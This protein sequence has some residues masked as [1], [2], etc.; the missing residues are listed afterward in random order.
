[1][2]KEKQY[3]IAA[4]RGRDK[5]NPSLLTPST[6]NFEQRLEIGS[7]EASN[8]LTTV[9]KDNLVV[10]Q[11]LLGWSRDDNGGIKNFHPVEVSNCIT[12]AKR[13]NTQNYVAETTRCIQVA[14]LHQEGRHDICNRVYSAE[15]TSPTLNTCGGGGLEPKILCNTA[16]FGKQYI[17]E[18]CPTI[19]SSSWEH[20][21]VLIE[22]TAEKELSPRQANKHYFRTANGTIE[23][24]GGGSK[25]EMR[26]TEEVYTPHTAEVSPTVI[27]QRQNQIYFTDMEQFIINGDKDG[28]ASTI[29]TAHHYTGNIT[30]PKGGHKEMGVLEINNQSSTEMEQTIIQKVGDRNN[31]SLSEKDIAFTC[32]ANPMS[33]RQQMVKES[34]KQPKAFRIRR[35]TPRECYRLMDVDEDNINRLLDNPKLARTKHYHLAGN[36]IVVA[37]L[38]HIFHRLFIDTEPQ[39]GEQMKLF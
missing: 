28:N 25:N 19:K 13:D 17:S 7:D 31:P 1:M 6:T 39:H 10:E 32:T 11:I 23:A 4:M 12:V 27:A 14:D 37:C 26:H 24:R 3:R 2:S 38:E 29:T 5:D 16:G 18:V 35:L 30:N 33:D 36:S 22:P 20:N 9:Q 15:G 34:E 8:A 21:N